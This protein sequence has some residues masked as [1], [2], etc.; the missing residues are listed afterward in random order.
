MVKSVLVFGTFDVLHLGHVFY[1]NEAKSL[2][3]KLI[4][5]VARDK[6]VKK[7]K[8]QQP[9]NSEQQRMDFVKKIPIVDKVFLGKDFF[10]DK[11]EIIEKIKPQI[12]A[13]GYDHPHNEKEIK[14]ELEKR[15]LNCKIKRMKAHHPEKYKSS[16]IKEKIF[17]K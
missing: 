1:L 5:I 10:S 13:F 17:S 16:K 4:V 14:K 11:F 7:L 3:D 12:I 9:L 8:K 6:T 2:G 15:G